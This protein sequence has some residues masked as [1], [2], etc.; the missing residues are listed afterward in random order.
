MTLATASGIAAGIVLFN[1]T[2]GVAT[3][4]S[5]VLGLIVLAMIGL[6]V[7]SAFSPEWTGQRDATAAASSTAEPSDD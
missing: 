4:A 1:L 6:T 2:T 3:I 7:V 5:V